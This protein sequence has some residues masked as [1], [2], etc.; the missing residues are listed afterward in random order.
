MLEILF[1]NGD[2]YEVRFI[3]TR[4]D[5]TSWYVLKNTNSFMGGFGDE[6][7]VEGI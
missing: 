5:G 2:P 6:Y 4:D 3:Y 1:I 7:P